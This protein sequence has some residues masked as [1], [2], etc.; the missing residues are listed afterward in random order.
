MWETRLP[1]SHLRSPGDLL[2]CVGI[3]NRSAMS[4]RYCS[5]DYITSLCIQEAL[6]YTVHMC[7]YTIAAVEKLKESCSTL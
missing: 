1:G 5:I 4:C 7:M 2:A 6:L 3:G